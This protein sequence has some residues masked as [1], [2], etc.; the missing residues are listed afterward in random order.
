MLLLVDVAGDEVLEALAERVQLRMV[1]RALLPWS[2]FRFQLIRL[3]TLVLVAMCC[4]AVILVDLRICG[5][6][7]VDI[8]RLQHVLHV[9][10]L[11]CFQRGVD[12]VDHVVVS[13][14]L[15]LFHLRELLEVLFRFLLIAFRNTR[16]GR[17]KRL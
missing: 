8:E 3:A 17:W 11:F 13:L 2:A 1:V 7:S 9:L 10:E 4:V 15:L 14:L 16:K 12:P 5:S 6:L